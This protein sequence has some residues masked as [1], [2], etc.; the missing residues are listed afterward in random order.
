MPTPPRKPSPPDAELLRPKEA[1]RRLAVSDKTL[2]RL[3]ADGLI[4]VRYLRVPGS[5][6]AE[7]RIV[8]SSLD[9]YI[10]DLPLDP[11]GAA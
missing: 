4:E 2:R 1:C 9:D 6:Q 7:R 8:A 3:V 5:I 11:P 10:A